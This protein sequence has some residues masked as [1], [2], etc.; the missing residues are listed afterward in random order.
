[1]SA[2]SQF[3]KLLPK[4][5]VKSSNM[6]S[7]STGFKFKWAYCSVPIV[8]TASSAS[9]PSKN[10]LLRSLF[11][12]SH[13]LIIECACLQEANSTDPGGSSD[14]NAI[15]MGTTAPTIRS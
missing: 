13:L 10:L 1:M 6:H 12:Y 4:M 7:H 11:S 5:S 14:V 8:P 2:G 15:D 3:E 9:A